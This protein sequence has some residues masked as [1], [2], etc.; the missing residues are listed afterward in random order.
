M[1]KFIVDVIMYIF[2]GLLIF[3]YSNS[4]FELK[5]TRLVQI[6]SVSAGITVLFFI[7]Q[8]NITYLNAIFVF[9]IYSFLFYFLYNVSYKAAAFHTV[10][11]MI[12]MF[13][14]EMLVMA[15]SSVI[16]KDFN[17]FENEIEPYLF[18]IVLSKM[19]YFAI[20]M[21]ILKL[22]IPNKVNERFNRY[23]WLLFV[24]PL[25]SILMLMC[26][27]YVTYQIEL[28]SNMCILWVITCTGMLFSNILVFIIYE[29][30]LK[31]T[32][33]LYELQEIRRQEEQDKNYF[34]VIQQSNN[35]MRIFAHDIKNHL[36]Q[37]DNF[38]SLDEVHSYVLK[39]VPDVEKFSN[40]GISK[41]KMLDLIIS[42]Y[43]SLC[44]SKNIRFDID[45]KTAN[46]SY[47]DD[48]DLSTLMNNL[49]DNALESA[50]KS[51][52]KYIKVNIFSKNNLYDGLIIKNSCD[53]MPKEKNGELSTTKKNFK[54]HGIGTLSIKKV[55]KK[56][57]SV[58]DWKYDSKEKL[59]ETDIVFR[60]I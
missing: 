14:S 45:V 6:L 52:G 53:V 36:I 55:V 28:D 10:I 25:T 56:Y 18:V 37:I 41:N 58:Y 1:L 26:F 48:V 32:S 44:E 4:I 20:M 47:I 5:R 43:V 38:N 17:A 11:F 23:Y 13:A 9:I 3:Y 49:L 50:E 39:L 40:T 16:Y 7:Y 33:D 34:E 42:K 46:L 29:H 8:F 15:I 24:M 30:S 2:E 12:V 54:L 22:F 57:N 51:K 35:E 27:R 19:V 60:K 31:S 59:F 21:I